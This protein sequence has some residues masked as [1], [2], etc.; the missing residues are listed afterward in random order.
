MSQIESKVNIILSF[1]LLLQFVLCLI[2]A[3]LNYVFTLYNR[4]EKT[5]YIIWGTNYYGL[6]AVLIFFSYFV[7]INT[8]IPISLI[9]SIE[10][11]K[12][13]QSYFMNKDKLAFSEERQRGMLVKS[14]SLNE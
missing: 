3:I 13:S 6:D 8:M 4:D 1:I 12:V 10:V 14:S 2:T 9:V 11:V 7:L 5:D